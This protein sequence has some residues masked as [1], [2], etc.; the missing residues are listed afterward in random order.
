MAQGTTTVMG[1]FEIIYTD[2]KKSISRTKAAGTRQAH[3]KLGKMK[4]EL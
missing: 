2:K 4:S 3:I 1:E